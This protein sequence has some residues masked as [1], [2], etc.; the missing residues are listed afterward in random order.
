MAIM[1]TQAMDD[2]LV[3]DYRVVVRHAN[4]ESVVKEF[5]AFSEFYK[6]P[7]PNPLTLTIEGL[8]ANTAYQIEVHAMDAYGNLCK[9][10]LRALGK[11]KTLA[12][13]ETV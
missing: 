8:Q 9:R 2:L 12:A 3:H 6:D 11:T 10:P 5:L 13:A 4:T 7:V 1:F